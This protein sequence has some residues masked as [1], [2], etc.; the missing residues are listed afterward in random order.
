MERLL[1]I[2]EV[3][4][5]LV[6]SRFTIKR[7]LKAGVLPFVRINRNVVRIRE[8][9]LQHLIQLRLTRSDYWKAAQGQKQFK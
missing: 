4:E 1:T 2:R 3:A 7:M 9:D 8:E 5:A 6:L